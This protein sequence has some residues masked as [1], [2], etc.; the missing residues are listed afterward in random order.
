MPRAVL[1]Q[2]I[3]LL[4]I[5]FSGQNVITIG[6]KFDAESS[7]L[8][9][10]KDFHDGIGRLVASG[11]LG[12]DSPATRQALDSPEQCLEAAEEISDRSLAACDLDSALA[13]H[14]EPGLETDVLNAMRL[15]LGECCARLWPGR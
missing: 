10:A 2:V 7:Q 9:I 11:Q 13:A 4:Q 5:E 6:P 14:A 12:E 3:P 8:T 1:D 15:S